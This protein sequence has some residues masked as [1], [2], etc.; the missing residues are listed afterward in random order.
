MSEKPEDTTLQPGLSAEV[1]LTVSKAETATHLGS[2]SLAVYATPA[3]VA[4]MENA[5]VRVLEGHLP[6]GYTSV[7]GQI[8][9]RHLGATPVGMKVRAH[10]ELVEARGRKLTFRIQAWD[11]VELIGEADH[12]RFLVEEATFMEKVRAKESKLQNIQNK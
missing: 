1:E 4:L 7:G 10:A 11:E 12:V 8:D 6:P 2:G 9:V 3:L 5:A